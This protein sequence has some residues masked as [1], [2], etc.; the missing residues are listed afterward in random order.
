MKIKSAL[1]IAMLS[2]PAFAFAKAQTSTIELGNA[3][4]APLAIAEIS[5][6]A[7]LD[8]VVYEVDC[9]LHSDGKSNQANDVI[10][11]FSSQNNSAIFVLNGVPV[12]SMNDQAK[13]ATKSDV[14]LKAYEVEKS[15][16]FPGS[17]LTLSIR[18]LDDTDTIAITNCVANPE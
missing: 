6:D 15:G 18:N 11:L 12:S 8:D 17:K 14:T 16:Q 13:L 7:L 2:L 4:A 9:T 5:L 3:V 10:Q 1:V